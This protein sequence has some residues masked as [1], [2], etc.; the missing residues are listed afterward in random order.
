MEVEMSTCRRL[1]MEKNLWRPVSD[2]NP[3]KTQG[4]QALALQV[5]VAEV[6]LE[7]LRTPGMTKTQNSGIEA[8]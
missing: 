6:A 7:I 1:A 2:E 3:P 4:P 8:A 5:Q